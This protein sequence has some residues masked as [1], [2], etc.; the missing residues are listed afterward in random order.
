MEKKRILVIDDEEDL[1]FLIKENLEQTGK[2]DVITLSNALEAERTVEIEMP[3]LVLLDVVMPGK[4][5]SDIATALKNNPVTQRIPIIIM[6]GLG[7]MVYYKNLKRWKWL[8]NR[9]IV[10]KR[11]EVIHESLPEHA[12]E[13]YGVDDYIAKPFSTGQLLGLISGVLKSR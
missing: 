5:G 4:K 8:P 3:D 9:P 6:S 12:A 13:A 2:F 10:F 7:E 1:C 11:G